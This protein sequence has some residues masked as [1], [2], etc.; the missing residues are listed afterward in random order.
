MSA[1]AIATSWNHTSFSNIGGQKLTICSMKPSKQHMLDA[2]VGTKCPQV[3]FS[4]SIECER[5]FCQPWTGWSETNRR[6]PRQSRG[7][8]GISKLF[9]LRLSLTLNI[10]DSDF[11]QILSTQYD[12][13]CVICAI[14][15][16][17]WNLKPETWNLNP[18]KRRALS[19]LASP[20]QVQT[21]CLSLRTPC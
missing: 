16:T 6:Q 13:F 8:V 11:P 14:C 12:P 10:F 18:C 21:P 2:Y 5:L 20:S 1:R 4:K 15:V 17:P 3:L 7:A 9:S 19:L